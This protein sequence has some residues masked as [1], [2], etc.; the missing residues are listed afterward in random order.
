LEISEQRL[1]SNYFALVQ[2]AASDAGTTSVLAVVK[3]GAYGHGVTLCAQVLAAAGAPWLGV[4]DAEEGVAVRRSL[5]HTV[6][7]HDPQPRILVMCGPLPGDAGLIAK[8]R[9]TP[10]VWTAE[11]LS[12]LANGVDSKDPPQIHLEI[13]TGMS[14]QGVLPGATLDRFLDHLLG[15]PKFH[16]QGVLTHFVSAEVAGASITQQQRKRFEA[17]LAQIARRGFTP[18]W[19]HAGSSSTIDEASSL[20]WLREMATCYGAHSLVRS[21]LALYGYTL[22][23][24]G[25]QGM[26]S[27]KLM[28]VLTWKSRI[29]NLCE[30]P[31]GA[32]I[33]YNATFTAQQTTRL[34]LLPVGYADGLRRELSATNSK[35]GGWTIIRGR[36]A[37]IVGRISMNLTTVDVT[38]IADVALEDEVTLLGEGI[39]ADAHARIAHT[40]PY[41]ILCGLRS[42]PQLTT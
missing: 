5:D 4:T 12:S 11:Q 13:D 15:F 2:A 31:A 14:R 40:S 32:T 3:A 19:I 24:E 38:G 41:E 34:A 29:V 36:R 6:K 39:T 10:V 30:V 16:L 20:S 1:R 18:E 8:S 27:P 37:P 25:G 35:P 7:S 17:A 28:P 42:P 9:L 33:G 21:G 26:L 23:I 22:P